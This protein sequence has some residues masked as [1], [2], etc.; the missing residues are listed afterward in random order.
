M[1]AVVYC[2]SDCNTLFWFH[3]AAQVKLLVIKVIKTSI[4]TG[5]PTKVKLQLEHGV[6]DI[7]CKNIYFS[8]NFDSPKVGSG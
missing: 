8:V 7:M 6:M 2:S 4:E 1:L 3:A 5:G